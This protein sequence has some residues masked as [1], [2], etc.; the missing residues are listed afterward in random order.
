MNRLFPLTATLEEVNC[1]WKAIPLFLRL[2]HNT[3]KKHSSGIPPE[4]P[5]IKAPLRVNGVIFNFYKH[6]AQI[7]I[8]AYSSGLTDPRP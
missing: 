8:K 4:T 2:G 5:V 1:I 6:Q 3:T 7:G